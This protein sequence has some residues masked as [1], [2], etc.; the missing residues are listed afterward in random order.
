[1]NATPAPRTFRRLTSIGLALTVGMALASCAAEP[2]ETPAE[3]PP[4]EAPAEPRTDRPD[5]AVQAD[6][7]EWD[8]PQVTTA[9]AAP[10]SGTA[11][12]LAT[13]IVGSWQHTHFDTGNGFEAVSKDIR[14]V[15]PAADQLIYCQH[16]PGVTDHAE[17]R[18]AFAL[19]GT[20]IVLPSPS[21]GYEVMAWSADSMLWLN[22]QDGSTYLLA[23]R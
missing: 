21:K 13:A 4:L 23:R 9:A 15:F 8:I 18:A 11:G 20:S 6:S 19:D 14:Y 7:C 16:V 1:M 2:A 5:A 3:L 10:P 22:N 12:D 17:H